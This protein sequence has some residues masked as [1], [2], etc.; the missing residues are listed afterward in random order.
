MEKP[1][2]ETWLTAPIRAVTPTVNRQACMVYIYPSGPHLGTRYL[3]G[4]KPIVIG[5]GEDCDIRMQDNSVSRK[6]ALIEP[7]TDGF[8]IRDKQSLNGIYINDVQTSEARLHDGD[9]I[10]IGNCIFRFLTGGNI[11]AEYYEEIHRMIIIDALTQAHNTR[12]LNE[13]LER[14]LARSARHHRPLSL[15][16][17]D[18]DHFKAIND[19]YGHLGGDHVLRELSARVRR[20]I[21]RE[22]LFARYGGEEFALVLVETTID[23]AVEFAERTRALVADEPFQFEGRAFSVTISLGVATTCGDHAMT[24]K[25]LIRQADERLYSAKRSGRNRTVAASVFHR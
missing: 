1:A 10:R 20:T 18:I 2:S 15:V 17:F 13:F 5:R 12:S 7:M 24:I 8:V 6:H 9:Y 19:E 22:D 4:D 21:R 11:E 23:Q 25:E 16:L 14:E 3:L